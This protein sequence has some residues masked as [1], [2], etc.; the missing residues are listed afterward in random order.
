MKALLLLLP[1]LAGAPTAQ[2]HVELRPAVATPHHGA[3]ISV[4]GVRAG[5]LQ[6]RL[7]GATDAQ[8]KALPWRSPHLADGTWVGTLPAPALLGLYAVELRT[9]LGAPIF[10]SRR[11]LF[12][13]LA[14]HF[15][16]L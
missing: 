2:P 6:V 8:G 1:L 4:A 3:A 5:T 12:R 11:W 14:T 9:G 13:V 16:E 7:D 15:E 10:G